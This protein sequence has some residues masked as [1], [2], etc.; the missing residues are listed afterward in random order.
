MARK[1]TYFYA[2]ITKATRLLFGDTWE[3]PWY[4]HKVGDVILVKKIHENSP[5]YEAK[6]GMS[7]LKTDVQ[8]KTKQHANQKRIPRAE[9]KGTRQH[10]A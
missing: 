1:T 5:Y 9:N 3:E 7:V 8:Q 4:S 2:T 6:N 10:C